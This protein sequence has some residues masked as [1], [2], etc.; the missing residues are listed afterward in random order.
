MTSVSAPLV[1][2]SHEDWA[3]SDFDI[4]D[5]VPLHAGAEFDREDAGEDWDVEMDFGK[6][7]GA[8]AQAVVAGIVSR[9]ST[10]SQMF[11]IRPP[12]PAPSEED[13]DE[14]EGVS[15]IKVAVLPQPTSVNSDSFPPIGDDDFECDFALPS[16]LTQLSLRPLSLH[17]QSSK[18]SLEWGESNQTT[19]SQSS[20]AYSTFGFHEISPST[21]AS[22]SQPETETD[23]D[24]E[25]LDG[26]VIPSGL[27]ES[28]HSAK[29]LAKLLE[30]KQKEPALDESIKIASPNPE[31]DMEDG[32]VIDDDAD[33]SPSRLLLN[34]Q[35]QS[36]H[37]SAMG[38]RAHNAPS[39]PP[40]ARPPSRLKIDRPRSPANPPPSS[41]RQFEKLKS[42]TSPPTRV[43][44][45][46]R[47]QSQ[48]ALL[49]ADAGPSSFLSAKAGSL[50][51]QKSH[52]GLKP[53]KRK[54][55]RKASLSSLMETSHAQASGSGPES[56]S[57]KESVARYEGATAASRAKAQTSSTGRMRSP[58]YAVP[59]ARPSTP[60]SNPAA[61]RLTMP[62]S[63]SRAKTRPPVTS[64]F[65]GTSS[66]R[67]GRTS[68]LPPRP[69]STT[70]LRSKA[71]A[72][73]PSPS[74]SAQSGPQILRKPK[75]QRTYGDGTELDGFD[76]LPTDRDKE[77]RYRVVPK[78]YGNR[79]P[80]AMYAPP[81]VEGKTTTRRKTKDGT[82]SGSGESF[83]F[84]L[85]LSPK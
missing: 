48:T 83:V 15:T 31:D 16:D 44:A 40:I 70:S 75:R 76:D 66:S 82:T 56:K 43:S 9:K 80:G 51:G 38:P 84:F 62:T 46:P 20:D 57:P 77:S 49:S 36:K 42:P 79:V 59:P 53:T 69:P 72:A 63:S 30:R 5:G 8:K 74:S 73:G 37:R 67:T 22:Q 64:V 23:D 50:R 6:T 34:A 18:N 39:R 68:P 58:D 54:L 26:L 11:T 33:F 7:G 10:S 35:Q 29:H 24:E 25:D 55:V 41:A 71:A 14:D 28:T 32:L 78:A 2:L 17:H 45:L 1:S 19:S 3:D 52:T 47:S 21:S 61:L 12:L 85:P 27:F 4:P 65:P 81:K 13:E 60:S